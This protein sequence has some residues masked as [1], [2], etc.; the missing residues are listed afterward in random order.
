[1]EHFEITYKNGGQDWFTAV[2]IADYFNQ[3]ENWGRSKESL[4]DIVEVKKTP[5]K[6]SSD[7]EP[8]ID[9]EIEQN[10]FD[11]MYSEQ[12]YPYDNVW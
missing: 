12:D 10:F 2:C 7:F 11:D 1:M 9:P 4:K 8:E 3:P 5:V 6:E